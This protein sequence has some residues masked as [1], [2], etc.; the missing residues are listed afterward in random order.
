[1]TKRT[2]TIPFL[3][4]VENEDTDIHSTLTLEYEE[5]D[6]LTIIEVMAGIDP[7]VLSIAFIGAMVDADDPQV[8]FEVKDT[9]ARILVA[10]KMV[11]DIEEF[12]KENN[13]QEDN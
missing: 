2:A 8:I 11:D 12:L 13:G 10:P 7:Q 6:G 5:G 4:T 1:M 9:E 3:V